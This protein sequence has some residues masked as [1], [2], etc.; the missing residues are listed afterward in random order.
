MNLRD[1]FVLMLWRWTDRM[2]AW[3]LRLDAR[4]RAEDAARGPRPPLSWWSKALTYAAAHAIMWGTVAVEASLLWGWFAA[5]LGA[6]AVG[7]WH[8]LGLILL[9]ASV[10]PAPRPEMSTVGVEVTGRL[11]RAVVRLAIGA[12]LAW[13]MR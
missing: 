10:T 11:K 2:N 1:H 8:A 3:S 4:K 6:P 7:L 13:C 5:P 12:V 9:L